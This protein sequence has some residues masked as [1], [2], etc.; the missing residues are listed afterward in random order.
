M[1][2]WLCTNIHLFFFFFFF[3]LPRYLI[4]MTLLVFSHVY[5][6]Q[7]LTAGAFLPLD[8]IIKHFATPIK[9]RWNKPLLLSLLLFFFPLCHHSD[10]WQT[11]KVA[12]L[13]VSL[14]SPAQTGT[15]QHS[16]R[17]WWWGTCRE[18]N[19]CSDSMH[20]AFATSKILISN[21]LISRSIPH[22]NKPKLQEGLP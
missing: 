13:P 8:H 17:V 2:V 16:E 19:A 15:C 10:M 6:I 9:W 11:F 14:H 4:T 5:E 22:H 20:K 3:N 7:H 18:T 21:F 12:P 1:R